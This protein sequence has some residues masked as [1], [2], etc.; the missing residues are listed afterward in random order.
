MKYLFH[1]NTVADGANIQLLKQTLEEASIP[2]MIRN[3][4]LLVA[5]GD[6]PFTECFPELWI[7]ND[8]DYPKAEEIVKNWRKSQTEI[9]APW[10]CPS[11]NETI[12][13]QFT[14]C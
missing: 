9:Q 7:L 4:N 8:K 1:A 11:C 10:I 5:M 2:C 13:G 12:E 14:S 6:I 3:E